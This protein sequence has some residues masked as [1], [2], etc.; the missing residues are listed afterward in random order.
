M[1]SIP[2][3]TFST[4]GVLTDDTFSDWRLKTNGITD[5]LNTISSFVDNLHDGSTPT[6]ITVNTDQSI[7]GVKT[8][9]AGSNIAPLLKV[10]SSGLYYEDSKLK[11][12]TAI[13][14]SNIVATTTLTLGTTPYT[15][16]LAPPAANAY[17]TGN[18]NTGKLTWN[19]EE[20]I[21][22]R[23][24]AIAAAAPVGILNQIVPV[25]TIS[26]YSGAVAP[27]G[28]LICDGSPISNAKYP[29]LFAQLGTTY[30]A[31]GT[32][33]NLQGRTIVGVGTGNDGANSQ[34]FTLG[35]SAGLY[36]HTLIT[37]EMPSHTHSLS[38]ITIGSGG[39]H[40]HT[41]IEAYE[42]TNNA[43]KGS[44]GYNTW[45]TRVSSVIGDGAHTHPITGGTIGSAGSNTPFDIIQPYLST[46][47]IIKALPDTVIST[48]IASGDGAQIIRNSDS[49][50][51]QSFNIKDSD[52]YTLSVK[53]DSTLAIS[54]GSLGIANA[55]I[56][57]SEIAPN[58]ITSDKLKDSG[59]TWNADYVSYNGSHLLTEAA[60]SRKGNV[61]QLRE[62]MHGDTSAITW[63]DFAYINDDENVVVTGLGRN[64]IF[65]A[66]HA[67]GH[68][69]MPLP[70]NRKAKKLYISEY[71][72][73]CIDD[74]G[75]LWGTGHNYY[76]TFNLTGTSTN[77][78]VTWTRVFPQILNTIEKIVLSSYTTYVL[79]TSG[80]LWSAGYNNYGQ[81]GN[82]TNT[83]T[84]SIPGGQTL[85]THTNVKDIVVAGSEDTISAC[86]ITVDNKIW[87]CG[88]NG[89][90]QLGN[91][92]TASKNTWTALNSSFDWTNYELYS[93]GYG[94]GG[95]FFAKNSSGSTMYA[96]GY[97]GDNTFGIATLP[98]V[99]SPYKVWDDN[100]NK[101]SK[102]YPG[103]AT[104]V[105]YILTETNK[106]YATGNNSTGNFGN[107]RTTSVNTWTD[108]SSNLSS[109]LPSGYTL[110]DLYVSDSNSSYVSIMI[111]CSKIIDSITRYFL[112]GT[113]VN[114]HGQ[115][116]NAGTAWNLTVF[117]PVL[118]NSDVVADIKDV[119]IAY[120]Y[121]NGAYT[122]LL[123]NGGELYWAGFNDFTFDSGIPDSWG[124]G[125]Y[126]TIFNRV[127]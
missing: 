38:G 90:G 76:N 25:G 123:L 97:N 43:I 35:Q 31:S 1:D 64:S 124:T 122:L 52:T 3:N 63:R 125:Q 117:T 85:A 28:W 53:H 14:S 20:A 80:N 118:I 73:A 26:A 115:L 61:K 93:K 13:Q 108:L 98:A 41:Y 7:T 55:S 11:S 45:A 42:S 56:T 9:S 15:V 72:M 12:T 65:G 103:F 2:F 84:N 51:V 54:G 74:L 101:I 105:T 22:N 86:I 37:A 24:V 110:E 5:Q 126:R 112:F 33:P 113:G 119:Q 116:G 49:H 23:V 40:T 106:I 60:N 71:R 29:D 32:L 34:S 19:S 94:G 95:G 79:D 77:D 83:S 88:W 92:N 75:Q 4:V 50:I 67:Y 6:Y 114:F 81:L 68:Q 104:G 16:P 107:G 27:T 120:N 18:S 82:G 8:F 59:L 111:K 21:I 102:F 99:I 100:G 47:Y 96:W 109:N 69:L 58:T 66:C 57:G 46:I 30:G 48:L 78:L 39:A 36:K 10:G 91:G 127:K 121:P 44:S 87:T 17:L 62:K 89:Y 70:L